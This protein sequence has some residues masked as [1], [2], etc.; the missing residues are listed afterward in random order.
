MRKALW[1]WLRLSCTLTIVSCLACTMF[2]CN[3][4]DCLTGAA[5]ERLLTEL[6]LALRL[7]IPTEG[8]R[9]LPCSACCA[10]SDTRLASGPSLGAA[11]GCQ[12]WRCKLLQRRER[13]QRRADPHTQAEHGEVCSA[14]TSHDSFILQSAHS[15]RDIAVRQYPCRQLA[16]QIHCPG[17]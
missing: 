2:C 9:L 6:H 8:R 16:F 10:C 7:P 11:A 1:S 15:L 17:P 13:T 3:G 4:W 12:R 5:V 14:C